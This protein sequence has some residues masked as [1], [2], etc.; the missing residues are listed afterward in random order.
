MPFFTAH[1]VNARLVTWNDLVL[2]V[3][4]ALIPQA[5]IRTLRFAWQTGKVWSTKKLI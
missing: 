2:A 4:I 5:I 3:V 1:T